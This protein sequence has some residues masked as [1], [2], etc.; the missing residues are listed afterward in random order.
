MHFDFSLVYRLY[1]ECSSVALLSKTSVVVHFRVVCRFLELDQFASIIV[2][3]GICSAGT[4]HM[5]V[6]DYPFTLFDQK[7]F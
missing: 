7:R 4:G 6:L 3:V 5:R 2:E 1:L